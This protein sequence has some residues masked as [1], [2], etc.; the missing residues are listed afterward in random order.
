[1]RLKL[2]GP[3]TLPVDTRGVGHA[4]RLQP[5]TRL[6]SEIRKLGR[7]VGFEHG[8]RLEEPRLLGVLSALWSPVRFNLRT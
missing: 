4:P 3:P 7:R 8:R 2:F 5:F 1:M 6:A